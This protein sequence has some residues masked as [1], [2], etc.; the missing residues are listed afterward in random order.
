MLIEATLNIV[1]NHYATY[2][3][4]YNSKDYCRTDQ[5]ASLVNII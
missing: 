4:E 1:V 5:A 3:I 2:S